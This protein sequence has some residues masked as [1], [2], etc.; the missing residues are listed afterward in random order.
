[1]RRTPQAKTAQRAPEELPYTTALLSPTYA[2]EQSVTAA[3]SMRCS[4]ML[5]AEDALVLRMRRCSTSATSIVESPTRA[6]LMLALFGHP[7]GTNQASCGVGVQLSLGGNALVAQHA[8]DA[9]RKR[10]E[11]E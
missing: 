10:T 11:A 2:D 6:T 3:R 4:E 5:G 8:P 1:M 9:A 7:D